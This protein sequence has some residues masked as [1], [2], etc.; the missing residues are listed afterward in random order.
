MNGEAQTVPKRKIAVIGAARTA[1][2]PR[3][4]TFRNAVKELR[5]EPW[6]ALVTAFGGVLMG[7]AALIIGCL[8][9]FGT[10]IEG[11]LEAALRTYKKAM[12]G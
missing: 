7:I 5:P 4:V 10:G 8:A 9:F 12:R 3:R 1:R 11:G 6:P 2:K